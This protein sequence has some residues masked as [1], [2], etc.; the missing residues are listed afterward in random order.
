MKHLSTISAFQKTLQKFAF[1]KPVTFSEEFAQKRFHKKFEVP[2]NESATARTEKCWSD[3]IHYDQSIQ[4]FKSPLLFPELYRARVKNVVLHPV[5]YDTYD[6]PKGSEF[7][8]TMGQNSVESRLSRSVWTCTKDNFD[9]FAK[10]VYKHKA[11]KRAFRRRYA[12]WFSKR[13]V[14]GS[15]TQFDKY[16]FKRFQHHTKPS[17][18]CFLW[19][20]SVITKFV[21][22]S[23]FSQVPKNN[24]VNRP[25]NIEPFGNMIVQRQVGNHLRSE[26]NRVFGHDLDTLASEH[27]KKISLAGIA[28][29]DLKNASDSISLS[30]CEWFF[31]PHIAN[32][33]RK[34]RSEFILGPD[35]SYHKLKK[36]SSMG[37][38]FTFELMTWII[39]SVAKELDNESSVFGDDIIINATKARRLIEILE[40]IGFTVNIEK[41]FIDGPFKES[42]GGN[43]HEEEGYIKS[44]DFRYP[45][46]IHD[47]VIIYNKAKYLSAVY[48]S[49]NKLECALRR[50]VPRALQ[51]GIEDSF[52]KE[53][54]YCD[55]D[56]PP[57]I[58][59]NFF[60][61]GARHNH[62]VMPR[63]VRELLLKWNYEPQEVKIFFGFHFVPELRSPTLKSLKNTHHWAK[64]EMYLQSGRVS[65]DVRVGRGSW[66][67]CL[68]YEVAG[69]TGKWSN[70][71]LK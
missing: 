27:R 49:F 4:G 12:D 58:L 39:T 17:W 65:K 60:R 20:L 11:M 33:L 5:R 23:R 43:F 55:D 29:I 3:W 26:L 25:I 36:I 10:F 54:I 32:T 24:L 7:V 40:C 22:G 19:K 68:F 35:G 14:E 8:A 16:L 21:H 31:P 71:L 15:M 42:C 30:F 61:T 9:D 13:D 69:A 46:N 51:G 53:G 38:G 2:C 52:Y 44:F 56:Q 37:N 28:T 41:S 62:H 59:S 45:L 1:A 48:P 34:C 67:S 66:V 70:S 64:Y 18:S 57:V 47:C 50:H 6:L 63:Q